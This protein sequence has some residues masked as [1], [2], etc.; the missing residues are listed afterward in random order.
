MQ[1]VQFQF[2]RDVSSTWTTYNP[3]LAG[4]E[5]GLEIDTYQYKIGDGAT[6]WNGLLYGGVGGSNGNTGPTGPP[7]PTDLL[8]NPQ[9]TQQTSITTLQQQ[10]ATLMSARGTGPT[11]PS[12]SGYTITTIGWFTRP[13]G[14]AVDS[15]GNVYVADTLDNSIKKI[16]TSNNTTTIGSGFTRPEGVT[17]DSAGN[18]YVADTRNNAIKKIDTSNNTTTIGSAI[19]NPTQVAVNSSGDVYATNTFKIYKITNNITTEFYNFNVSRIGVDSS[20]TVYG[21]NS[22]GLN[23]FINGIRTFLPVFSNHST[24]FVNSSG[25]LYIYNNRFSRIDKFVNGINTPLVSHI[26]DYMAVDSFGNIY[27]THIDTNEINKITFY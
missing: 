4:G 8:T 6:P 23:I 27:T 14:I 1:T 12:V 18:V 10:V 19:N 15:I 2:R 25:H 20:G 24:L 21:T 5:I 16:D 3:T 11:G 13:T 22:G 9:Q 7:G 17:V 26:P